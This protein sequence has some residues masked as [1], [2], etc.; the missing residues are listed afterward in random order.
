MAAI[1]TGLVLG[2]VSN[3]PTVWSNVLAAW[4][5]SGSGRVRYLMLAGLGGTLLYVGGM[6]LNDACDAG[7]DRDYRPERPI[8]SGR[9]SEL[10]VWIAGFGLLISGW[11]VLAEMGRVT[12]ALAAAL[13][14]VIALYDVLH[15]QVPGAPVL[16]AACRVLLFMAA[17]S[18]G[19]RVWTRIEGEVVW[20]AL[21]LGGYVVGLSYLAKGEATGTRSRP[22]AAAGLALPFVLAGFV[23]PSEHWR[24]PWVMVPALLL[25]AWTL[26][27]VSFLWRGEPRAVPRTVSGLLAGIVWVDLLAV[28]PPAWPWGAAFLVLF[29][30]AVWWQRSVPA[31]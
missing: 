12:A 7:F 8:P 15:K 26:R 14:V 3:L 16:M 28:L 25:A 19:L 23:N 11:L 10:L 17:G 24:E 27:S 1:R 18:G 13:V 5:I 6:F 2:R 29:G 30:T 4:L 9:A 22:W 21:V 31:T 20:S